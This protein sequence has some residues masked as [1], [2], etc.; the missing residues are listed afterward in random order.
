MDKI[1]ELI[2]F[3]LDPAPW[4]EGAGKEAAFSRAGAIESLP[5]ILEFWLQKYP[6]SGVLQRWLSGIRKTRN[7]QDVSTVSNHLAIRGFHRMDV[8]NIPI[9]TE[10]T[11]H[12][13]LARR[14]SDGS[15]QTS[16]RRASTANI[17]SEELDAEPE[18]LEIHDKVKD[19]LAWLN[20]PDLR[21]AS[22][23]RF[24][25]ADDF[26]IK[27]Y[28]HILASSVE[29]SFAEILKTCI[30]FKIAHAEIDKLQTDIIDWIRKTEGNYV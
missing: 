25:L 2:D 14:Q 5:M 3:S 12:R 28:L 15:W 10:K 21:T 6:E 1:N 24:D 26:D 29:G 23:G 13:Q 18:D 22:T 4:V 9:G 8:S 17:D 27:Q 30:G 11:S 19:P 16:S 7:R 20:L